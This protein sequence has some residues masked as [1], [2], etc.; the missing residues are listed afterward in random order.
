MFKKKNNENI[1]VL[2]ENINYLKNCIDNLNKAIEKSRIYE[3]SE[4]V[5]NSKKMIL[6][7][8][9]SGVFI[10]VGIGV[11]FYII[12]AIVILLLNYIVKLNIPVIGK[13]IT[14]IVEIVEFN[15]R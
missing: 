5:G 13:Y 11:G 10:G 4:V 12:T 7:N 3:F 8:F 6:K 2:N 1:T 14:D 15:R 9:F